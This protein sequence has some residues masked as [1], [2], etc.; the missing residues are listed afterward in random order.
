V[1]CVPVTCGDII[2]PDNS[3]IDRSS[4][5]GSTFGQNITLKCNTGYE[6]ENDSVRTEKCMAD[7]TWTSSVKCLAIVCANTT[8]VNN[9]Q[10]VPGN[11]TFESTASVSCN[12]GYI[13]NGLNESICQ[14]NTTWTAVGS[15]DPITCD[16]LDAAEYNFD[17]E[18]IS[19]IQFGESVTINC[20]AGH[21][22]VGNSPLQC[23]ATGQ[24]PTFECKAF[25]CSEV[26]VVANSTNTV[27]INDTAVR[28]ICKNGFEIQGSAIVVCQANEN[29]SVT[30]LCNPVRCENFTVP[31]N[32]EIN[33]NSAVGSHFNDRIELACLSGYEFADASITS[34]ICQANQT[35]TDHVSCVPVTCGDIILPDNSAIDRSSPE[36]STFGQ[37]ITLKCNTGYEFANNSFITET[38]QADK[39]WTS[40]IVCQ[41]VSCGNAT[42]P[43]NSIVEVNGSLYG[44][45]YNV[46]CDV[47]FKLE[48]SSEVV[49]Q[50]NKT[51]STLPSCVPIICRDYPPMPNM[52]ILEEPPAVAPFN[53]TLTLLCDPGYELTGNAFITCQDDGNWT[54]PPVCALRDCDTFTLENSPNNTLSSIKFNQSVH[55]VCND[56]Y[57]LVP[58]SLLACLPNGT[59]PSIECVPVTCLNLTTPEFGSIIPDQTNFVFGEEIIVNC[60][61]GYLLQGNATLSCLPDGTWP[62]LPT[63]T[64]TTCGDLLAPNNSVIAN[65]TGFT[66]NSTRE[67]NCNAG[68]NLSGASVS[69]CGPDGTWSPVGE[70]MPIVCPE[71]P[72]YENVIEE[73]YNETMYNTTIS[74]SCK[75]G[76]NYTDGSTTTVM[77]DASGKWVG[78]VSCA[79]VECLPFE[80]PPNSETAN[81]IGQ[82]YVFEDTVEIQCSAGYLLEGDA[83]VTCLANGSWS[84]IPVCRN[85]SYCPTLQIDNGSINSTETSNGTAV[86]VMCDEGYTLRGSNVLTCSSVG[87]WSD[88]T[89]CDIV[90]CGPFNGTPDIVV[91]GQG[92]SFNTTLSVDCRPGLALDDGSVDSVYCNANGS[93]TGSPQCV[94]PGEIPVALCYTFS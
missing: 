85:V 39:S 25:N 1:S 37:N 82:Q 43:V 3:A 74:L 2:L 38:C 4:P 40:N 81:T 73:S 21:S 15:C 42:T 78:N 88:T 55:L 72:P 58:G 17:G 80:I 47:G 60:T 76:F 26:P 24:W 71:L 35:W 16:T 70:C 92:E 69:T 28:F 8:I 51:W 61:S 53:T 59:W 67:I 41:R 93:W 9:G 50:A 52:D 12:D 33:S 77:C 36:G 83:N 5:E 46:T 6:Y 56:G 91:R 34:E 79:R 48:G 10:F 54:E 86:A 94:I 89:T 32:A 90:M 11:L 13:L 18:N 27:T 62:K 68:F 75:E 22:Y 57:N 14:A 84:N 44:D 66:I 63:C 87:S 30:P 45:T 20:S 7:G 19:G 65:A 29:W 23:N 49:C 64:A 31:D